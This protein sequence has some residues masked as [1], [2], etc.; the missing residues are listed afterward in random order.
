MKRDAII[1]L[2]RKN[3]TQLKDLGVR[4]LSIFGSVARGEE[5]QMSDL[6]VLVEF[7]GQPT[8]DGFMDTKIYLEDLLGRKV[9]LVM[10]QAIKPQIK[11][12][13]LQDMI[14]VT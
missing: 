10:P 9:D 3:Q 5:T 14:H 2:I 11:P 13:I 4:S 1:S 8:F 6:D 7:E 12:H